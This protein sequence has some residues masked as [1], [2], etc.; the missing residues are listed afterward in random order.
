MDELVANGCMTMLQSTQAVRQIVRE[1]LNLAERF[2]EKIHEIGAKLKAAYEGVDVNED[3]ALYHAARIL[4]E[5]HDEIQQRLDKAR[6][7]ATRNYNARKIVNVMGGSKV[8]VTARDG[9]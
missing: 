9:A 5:S 1:H 4:S 7:A 6:A 2:S 8:K 3:A